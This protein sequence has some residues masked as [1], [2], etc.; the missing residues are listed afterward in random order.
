MVKMTAQI[1]F[2]MTDKVSATLRVIQRRCST[3]RPCRAILNPV[4][5]HVSQ[6]SASSTLL[7]RIVGTER[8]HGADGQAH[9]ASWNN[10]PEHVQASHHPVRR[11]V[12]PPEPRPDL[13]TAGDHGHRREHDVRHQ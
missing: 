1:R 8:A 6:T 9:E 12:A 3:N 4:I 13:E 11:H 2:V 7:A 5:V 10:A